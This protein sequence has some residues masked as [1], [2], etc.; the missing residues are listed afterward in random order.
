MQ[1]HTHNLRSLAARR[2]RRSSFLVAPLLTIASHGFAGVITV[3]VATD[4]A[5]VATA[6]ELRDAILAA[7]T[8]SPV[9]GCGAGDVGFD[10]IRF[11]LPADGGIQLTSDLPTITDDLEIVGPGLGPTFL[12]DGDDSFRLFDTSIDTQFILRNLRLFQGFGT[13]AACIYARG[14]TL[15]EDSA[16]E[17]CLGDANNSSSVGAVHARYATLTAR[18]VTFLGNQ[19]QLAGA[20]FLDRS[21]SRF[22]ETTWIGNSA[23]DVGALLLSHATVSIARST[24]TGNSSGAGAAVAHYHGAGFIRLEDSTVAGNT[25]TDTYVTHGGSLHVRGTLEIRNSVVADNVDISSIRDVPD[26][27]L[28]ADAVLTSLGSNFIGSNEGASAFTAGQP[29]A[30]GDWVGDSTAPLDP[31]LTNPTLN[32]GPTLTMM[33]MATS[34]LID[35]GSCPGQSTD[36]KGYGE[37]TPYAR[38]VDDPTQ[39]DTDDGC[40]IGSVERGAV[41]VGR[42]FA[43][44]F[45]SGN[46]LGWR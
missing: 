1:N 2:R 30:N 5:A 3:D 29:N 34:P 31:Q 35:A 37:L 27:F 46:T 20:V 28:G 17:A 38:A 39:P 44:A 42:I 23:R 24:F 18:R 32:G 11:A 25:V 40:D 41:D 15:V 16:I 4:G 8:N 21:D 9:N 13:T 22:E 43:D 12:L 10:Q 14:P 36:Q 33:P 45:E 19:G 7:N 6:C 26:V